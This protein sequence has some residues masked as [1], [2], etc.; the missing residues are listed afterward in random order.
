MSEAALTLEG[1]YALHDF[2]S[3]NWTAWTAADDE[4]R[5][6]ALD[7]LNAFIAEWAGVEEANLGSS[8]WYSIVGQKADFVMMHLRESLEDLNKLE[9]AFN[10]TAFAPFTTK[11]Y[12][13][14][15]IVELS[16]YNSGGESGE[17]PMQNPHI[18][19]RLKPVLPKARHICF[20]PMNKKRELADNWY[21]LDMAKRKE[22]MY[23]HGLIGRGYAGNVKQI[24]TGSVGFDDWEWGVTLFA[25]DALQ[26]KKLVYEMRFDEVS[27]RY[28]EFGSFYIGNLLTSESFEEMLKV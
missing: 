19:A 2:R 10:K 11:A 7:E 4:E 13:Y 3:L 1:W 14:V 6:V 12:S 25:E 27:A 21:M 9:A 22:L 28:G 17:D 15:S 5:A 26:F 24:I 16:N 20:Y 18:A 23:S 8:A